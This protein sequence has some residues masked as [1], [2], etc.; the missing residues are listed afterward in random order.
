M[1]PD[2]NQ[3]EIK[4]ADCVACGF[5]VAV[6]ENTNVFLQIIKNIIT[7]STPLNWDKLPGTNIKR[8]RLISKVL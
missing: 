2:T 6:S 8:S 1:G 3:S 5:R 4:V 7:H